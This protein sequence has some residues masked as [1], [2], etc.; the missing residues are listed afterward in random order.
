MAIAGEVY[1]PRDRRPIAARGAWWARAAA[2]LLARRRVHPNLISLAGL[3][4]GVGAGACL[5][6]TAAAADPLRRVLWLA[7]AALVQARLLANLLD[8]MVAVASG[9]ASPVGELYNEIPDRLSDAAIIA[10][11]GHAAGGHVLLGYWAAGAALLTAYVRA[12]AAV[13][14]AP[15]DYRG[16][17]AK[18]QRMFAVTIAALYCAVTP[19]GW[20]VVPGLAAVPTL[21]LAVILAGS[22][23]TAARRLG[24]AA[25]FHRARAR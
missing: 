7:A 2:D 19:A 15:Q 4:A 18:Q 17:M 20:Q 5:V 16:P 3:L 10:G 9:R 12:A 6:A 1:E 8:G 13:A 21:I 11:L 24:R 23:L 25:A 22:L 14:G